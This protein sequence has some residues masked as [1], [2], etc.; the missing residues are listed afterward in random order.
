MV[1]GHILDRKQQNEKLAFESRKSHSPVNPAM[2]VRV[3]IATTDACNLRCPNCIQ[4]YHHGH[5][6]P[7]ET[8]EWLGSELFPL[9]QEYHTTLA[10]EPLTT[11]YFREIPGVLQGY[12]TRMSFVTNGI[13]LTPDICELVMPVLRDIKISFDGANKETFQRVRPYADFEGILSNI[14]GFIEV[15]KASHCKPTITLLSTLLYDNI[16]E[17]PDIVEIAHD[18]GVD[19]VKVCFM[20]MRDNDPER[21]SLWFHKALA[22]EYLERAQELAERYGL[23]TKFYKR[24]DLNDAHVERAEPGKDCRFLWEEAWVKVDGDVVPCCNIDAPVV[25]NIYDTPFV[26]IWNNRLYQDMRKR[27]WSRTPYECC[28]NC[29]LVNEDVKSDVFD[30]SYRSLI[31]G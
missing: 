21:R 31:L 5:E 30:Y 24:F 8:F 2:P 19:R 25:G 14:R 7:F 16:R 26:D 4:P 22:N 9:A 28:E 15:R 1:N 6:I 12:G 29:I 3:N 11:S 20:V 18:L 13:L 10:G 17:L 27:V 23:K